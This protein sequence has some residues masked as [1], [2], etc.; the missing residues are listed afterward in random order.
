MSAFDF[1][2]FLYKKTTVLYKKS[3]LNFLAELS[4]IALPLIDVN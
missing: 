3:D 4:A 1:N 2:G